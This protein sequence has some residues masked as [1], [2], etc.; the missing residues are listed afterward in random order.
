MEIINLKTLFTTLKAGGNSFLKSDFQTLSAP[1]LIAAALKKVEV[2]STELL[3]TI[4]INASLFSVEVKANIPYVI[5]EPL[6]FYHS[7]IREWYLPYR[8]W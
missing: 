5:R 7:L 4:R 1:S 2:I 8:E 6:Y 3:I